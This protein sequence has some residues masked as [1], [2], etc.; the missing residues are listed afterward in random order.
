MAPPRRWR[1]QIEVLEDRALASD[2]LGRAPDVPLPAH[3]HARHRLVLVGHVS[4]TWTTEPPFADVGGPQTLR[5][6]GTVR[7]LGSVEAG[8]TLQSSGTQTQGTLRL[9][10][11][12]GSVT[13]QLTGPLLTSSTGT[14]APFQYTILG[15]TRRYNHAAGHGPATL[16]ET[17]GRMVVCPPPLL[18]PDFIVPGSFTLTFPAG[19]SSARR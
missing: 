13:L 2:L 5:G 10:T 4:G 9:T 17:P 19:T 8:G 12:G 6:S 11:A 14:S 16:A 18:C 15:G 3:R 1:P 7:P